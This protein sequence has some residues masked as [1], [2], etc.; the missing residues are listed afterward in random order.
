LPQPMTTLAQPRMDL[1]L[2]GLLRVLPLPCRSL[3]TVR[4][5][6]RRSNLLE[7]FA[8][9]PQKV[10]A[11]ST[12]PTQKIH[13]HANVRL[14][15]PRPLSSPLA[16]AP[17]SRLNPKR[18]NELVPNR[19][20][21]ERAETHFPINASHAA[22]P[23][24]KHEEILGTGGLVNFLLRMRRNRCGRRVKSAQQNDAARQSCR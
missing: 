20:S 18:T 11:C 21:H 5:S 23:M 13:T 16:P 1:L 22:N 17:L 9:V 24:T 6:R 4:L 19:E 2:E 12:K 15:R 8:H 7:R 3:G 14:L 10:R